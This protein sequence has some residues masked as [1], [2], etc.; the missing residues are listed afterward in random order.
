MSKPENYIESIL[1]KESISYIREK[2]FSDLKK[3]KLRYDFAI[4]HNS[5]MTLLEYDSEIHFKFIPKYHKTPIDFQAAKERDRIKNTYA[6]T[7]N[8]T[9]IRI[10]YWELSN[11][12]QFRDIFKSQF[13][14]SSKWHNDLLLSRQSK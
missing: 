9:L 8:I 3:G 5:I 10:P 6:I 13:I 12:K 14:V 1:Q 7:H 2:T 4:Y 11:I